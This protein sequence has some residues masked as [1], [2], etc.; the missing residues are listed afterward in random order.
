MKH[1]LTS[2]LISAA[3]FVFFVPDLLTA[4]EREYTFILETDPIPLALGGFSLH[5]GFAPEEL[6][7][8]IFGLSAIAGLT[9]PDFFIN[10]EEENKN[11]GWK[12]KVNQG[13]GLWTHY[14]FSVNREGLFVGAQLFTQE[15]LLTNDTYPDESDRTNTL[16]GALQAGY[17]FFPFKENNFYIRPW[18][19]FGYQDVITPTFEPENVDPDLKIG[20]KEFTLTK[21]APFITVHFGYAF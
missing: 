14:Y 8:F 10:L 18:G 7:H 6:P 1:R 16:M 4:T 12:L 3:I 15:L 19:G 2:I 11:Q 17:M 20:D 5:A 13:A 21:F 9:F